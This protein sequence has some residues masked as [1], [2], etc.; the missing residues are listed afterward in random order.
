[1]PGSLA[2]PPP[3]PTWP[4]LAMFGLVPL[5]WMLGG[6]YLGWSVFGVVLLGLMVT[7]G[8]VAL[9]AG[10]ACWLVLLALVL[11]SF[12]RLERATAYLTSGL[13]FGFMLTALIVCVYVYNLVRDG[14]PWEQ[15]LRPLGWYWLGVVALGW[16]AVL[17]PRFQL[18]TPVEMLL[19]G[20]M[21]GERFIQALTHVRANEFNPVSRAPIYRTAAPYPYTNNWGTAY[22]LLVPCVLAY[23][24][25]VRTGK[26]RVA[27]LVS[28]PL[29]MVPAFMTL[30]RG[31]FLGLG[32]GLTYLGLRAL[33]RGNAKL[34][35]SIGGL[36][37]LVWVV[38]LVVPVQELID[39]RVS[40]TDTNVDRMDLYVRTLQAVE[41]SPL[42]GYGAPNSVDTTLA[43]EPL[44]TQ[45]MIWQVL[46][47]H[48][49]PALIAFLGWLALI[50]K[51]L[52]GAVS[53]AGQWLSTIPVIA[54][55]VIPVYAYIDPNMSVIF[56]AVGAGLA[57]VSG[58]VN[59][60]VTL[61]PGV[62][63][64]RTSRAATA[65]AGMPS[66]AAG[67][68]A[69]GS[70]ASGGTASGGTAT[71]RAAP[72]GAAT[73]G[74]A[75]ATG[76]AAVPAR[77][78][79][80][81]PTPPTRAAAT[82]PPRSTR[83]TAAAP[84]PASP[85]PA[86][87]APPRSPTPPVA[88][89]PIPPRVPDSPVTATPAPP[90]APDS[91][92]RATPVPPATPAPPAAASTPAPRPPASSATTSSAAPPVPPSTSAPGRPAAPSPVPSWPPAQAP[93]R[94]CAPAP[95]S[96]RGAS[97]TPP[98]VAP[99]PPTAGQ[100]PDPMPRRTAIPLPGPARP[101]VP[102]QPSSPSASATPSPAP[103]P[104]AAPAAPPVPARIVSPAPAPAQ[105]SA[106]VQTSAP[107]PA[108]P[109]AT[110]SVSG[111]RPA[112]GVDAPTVVQPARTGGDT[113]PGTAADDRPHAR[114]QRDTGDQTRTDDGREQA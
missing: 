86:P 90:R 85:A 70:T 67:T 37:L 62:V 57:A 51:R 106:P 96:N 97:P 6:F 112:G 105:T 47:S 93:A 109:P 5:W 46:Y 72:G 42:L 58:P 52:A 23:L 41:R 21:S 64:A 79:A 59:R 49:I 76:T 31:M 11:L 50:A 20:S 81:V 92:V 18:T 22:A 7:R 27:L 80:T 95:A 8:R 16:L 69:S 71:G 107:A 26:F 114:D 98:P 1:M 75:T 28:L 25:S 54:L 110:A 84:P 9:P 87:G 102:D 60:T 65:G 66:S 17:A 3:L 38:S 48:G 10:T 55:V 12:T 34:I 88:A 61:A 15:V 4:L 40:S 74:A 101:P 39:N 43:E 100:V 35:A 83:A 2:G 33:V 53:P 111:P 32:A 104:T 89:S 113:P 78:S 103:S 99:P 91:P 29:S 56:F 19:P 63:D 13:R 45:G 36:V 108:R 77:A 44:G 30:N 94:P 82:V 68:V 14:V 73:G 24:T